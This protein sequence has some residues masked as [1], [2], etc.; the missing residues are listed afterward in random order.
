MSTE[1]IA[2]WV[3]AGAVV[4]AAGASIMALIVSALDRRN[5]RRIA[6]DDGR[7]DRGAH[8]CPLPG[9]VAAQLGIAVAKRIASPHAGV[10]SNQALCTSNHAVQ[11][12]RFHAGAPDAANPRYGVLGWIA[13]P[14][15][16]SRS[17]HS[18]NSHRRRIR[19]VHLVV[20]QPP[21]I[22]R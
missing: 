5:S 1:E 4:V 7:R 20:F 18:R 2:V 11:V 12:S 22:G 14:N 13:C 3:L 21:G 15:T 10:Q 9:E 17:D 8:W 16:T 19:R 6:A